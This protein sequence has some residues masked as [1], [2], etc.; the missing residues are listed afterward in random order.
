VEI[1]VADV[2][3]KYTLFLGQNRTGV[4]RDASFLPYRKDVIKAVLQGMLDRLAPDDIQSR[5][6]VASAYI[7]LCD[8]PENLSNDEWIAADIMCRIFAGETEADAVAAR[9]QLTPQVGKTYERLMQRQAAEAQH[10]ASEV[11]GAIPAARK[12]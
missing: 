10:L 12:D 2:L 4:I 1:D 5:E 6:A 3:Q 9:G 8:F 7:R 11:K